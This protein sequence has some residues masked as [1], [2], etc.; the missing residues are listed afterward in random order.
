[1]G[2]L[3]NNWDLTKNKEIVVICGPTACGKSATAVKMAQKLGGEVISADSAQIYRGMDIGTAK[4]LPHEMG[5]VIHHL[6]DELNPDEP[7]NVAIFAARAKALIA[8][9]S[10]RGRLPIICGGTGF[11]INALLYDAD[12]NQGA[13]DPALRQKLENF[14]NELLYQMLQEVDPKATTYIDK[15]NIKRIIRALEFHAA[16]G[17]QISKHNEQQREGRKI[18]YNAQIFVLSGCRQL[19]YDRINARVDDMITKGL[20]DE[21]AGLLSKY[22]ANLPSLQAL[23]YKEIIR[24]LKGEIT[25]NEAIN[26][27][28]QGTRRFAKRQITW[29][30][31]QLPESTWVDIDYC[32]TN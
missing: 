25:L 10:Q 21:V 15:N 13:S 6:I 23:G 17:Q 19:M 22:D 9:I 12:F 24:H 28:K 27:I 1:M 30:K 20:V 26:A 32:S 8:E 4:I 11:Y 16:T 3:S 5:G 31:H 18:A 7:Y 2:K 14:D 29:F